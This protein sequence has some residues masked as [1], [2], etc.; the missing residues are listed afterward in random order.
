MKKG[1][2]YVAATSQHIGKTTSTLGLVKALKDAGHN[3]GYCKPVGQKFVDM[4]D[5]RADKDALL[6]SK[7]AHFELIPDIHSPVILGKGATSDFLENPDK[8][9]Y[10][11]RIIHAGK[12]LEDTYDIIVYDEKI[13]TYLQQFTFDHDLF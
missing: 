6:F 12:I 7:F 11:E 2:V 8:Y 1:K 9:P 10:R 3:V 4:G 13:Q 5:L